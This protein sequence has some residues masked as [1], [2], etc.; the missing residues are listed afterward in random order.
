MQVQLNTIPNVNFKAQ[1][2]ESAQT[3]VNNG[4]NKLIFF[5][6]EYSG[7]DSKRLEKLT[8]EI[9]NDMKNTNPLG[10]H[11]II[12]MSESNDSLVCKIFSQKN[13]VQELK[14]TISSINIHENPFLDVLRDFRYK[15]IPIKEEPC[16]RPDSDFIDKYGNDVRKSEISTHY[17]PMDWHAVS[18]IDNNGHYWSIETM[19]RYY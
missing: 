16:K 11:A 1:F 9:V 15:L 13:G 18:G 8:K 10:G 2:T 5:P 14:E 6:P 7:K 19:G 17:T 12:D 3:F 4:I